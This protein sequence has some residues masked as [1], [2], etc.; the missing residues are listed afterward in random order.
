MIALVFRLLP[1]LGMLPAGAAAASAY[2]CTRLLYVAPAGS[3]AASGTRAAPLASVD[4]AVARALPGTC[5]TL[6][7]GVFRQ[8]VRLGRGGNADTATGYVVVR[9]E[10]P[11][12][13]MIIPPGAAASA[14]NPYGTYSVVEIAANYLVIDGIELSGGTHGGRAAG[15][16]IDSTADVT[17]NWHHIQVLNTVVHDMGGSGIQLG[18]GDWYEVTGNV[19]HDNAW[20]NGYQTSGISIYEPIGAAADRPDAVH[21][22]ITG[23]VSHDNREVAVGCAAADPLCHTDGNGIILDDFQQAQRPG[24]RPYAYRASVRRNVVFRNGG[25]GIEVYSG[26]APII[27]ENNTSY[28]NYG[29]PLNGGTFRGELYDASASN[30]VWKDNIA[31]ARPTASGVTRGNTAVLDGSCDTCVPRPQTPTWRGNVTFDGRPGEASLNIGSNPNTTWRDADNLPGVDPR[32][33]DAAHG[34]FALRPG[35]PAAGKGAK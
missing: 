18:Y 21:I 16:G 17:R 9:A 8:T 30:V 26:A 34:D 6:L 25:A 27:V 28:A 20:T 10:H 24:G 12:R 32:F 22:S 1:L 7:D 3:N 13:A 11:G 33:V 19:V 15:H 14:R 35:S 29:D 2:T 23:N 4:A 31:Y 5:V